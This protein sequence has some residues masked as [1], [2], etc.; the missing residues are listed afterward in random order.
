M[1]TLEQRPSQTYHIIF[2]F[3]GKRFKRSLHTKDLKRARD[4]VTRFED[5]VYRLESGQLEISNDV[6]VGTFLLS[7]GKINGTKSPKPHSESPTPPPQMTLE[8]AFTRFFA[9]I[10]EGNLETNTLDCMHLH[11][12]HLL[13]LFKRTFPIATL[14]LENLQKYVNKRAL[15]K[16]RRG[17]KISGTTVNKDLVTLGTM[18]RWAESVQLVHGPFPRRGLRLPK[19]AEL[20]PFRTWGEIERQLQQDN[21][22]AMEAAELW[23]ALYL[24]RSEIDELLAHIKEAAAHPFI[25]PMS[26]MAAHTGA[27]RSELLR[28]HCSDFDFDGNSVVIHEKKRIRGKTST[29][30]V[31]LSPSLKSAMIQWIQQAHPGGEFAFCLESRIARSRRRKSEVR[32]SPNQAHDHFQRTLSASKWEK[33]KGWHC[34]RHSFISNLAS[35]GIDQRIIDDFV[36]HT[37]EQMR[38]RY[39]HLFP[40]VKQAAIDAVFG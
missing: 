40:D 11:K 35:Q 33:I 26:L 9:S 4:C 14:S 32:L 5:T 13:R 2:W 23:E 16:T 34:L 1:A 25:Y 20:I 27:R 39:R 21:L 8:E 15:E 36:G 7:Q 31:P 10:P 6:D 29:R 17:T 28:S 19:T 30:R 22:G 24:R 12:R 3:N 38:R 18:W 37:T